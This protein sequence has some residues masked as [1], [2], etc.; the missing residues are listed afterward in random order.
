MSKRKRRL[1]AL[2]DRLAAALAARVSKAL[3][4]TYDLGL[5]VLSTD[6]GVRVTARIGDVKV[7]STL[8]PWLAGKGLDG[9]AEELVRR[10]TGRG[11]GA[12]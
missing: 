7:T 12:A 6:L 4:G 3:K 1:R 8:W 10:A 9:L 5:E 11:P 2:R